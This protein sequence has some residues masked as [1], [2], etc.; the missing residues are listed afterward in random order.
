MKS[1]Y[2][3][4]TEVGMTTDRYQEYYDTHPGQHEYMPSQNLPESRAYGRL[5]LTS[6]I[7]PLA[8]KAY[9]ISAEGR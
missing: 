4:K 5:L 1:I 7:F 8:T 6:L 2:C 9:L 3:N